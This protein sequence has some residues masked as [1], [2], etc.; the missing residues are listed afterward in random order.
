M[1]KVRAKK[2]LGQHFLKEK[3]IAK[4]IVNLLGNGDNITLEI[5][6]GMGVLTEFLIHQKKRLE[7]IE[8]D[9]ESVNYLVT[10]YPFLKRRIQNYDFLKL[11]IEGGEFDLLKND[12]K[13]LKKIPVIFAELHDRIVPKCEEMFFNFSKSRILIKDRGE[14]YLSIKR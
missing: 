5:G 11:D 14:K 2:F 3:S 12:I 8:I 10:K 1:K 6:P 13:T 4:K 9:I 7:L